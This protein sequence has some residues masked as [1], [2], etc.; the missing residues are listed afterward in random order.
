MQM[1]HQA[2]ACAVK[3]AAS[4]VCA[5]AH[6]VAV[7]DG[8]AIGVRAWQVGLN[9]AHGV[10]RIGICGRE[11]AGTPVRLQPEAESSLIIGQRA[12]CAQY[13]MLCITGPQ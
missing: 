8:V 12:L 5:V 13:S 6:H 10:Q 9:Q 11:T 7:A 1:P 4:E 3:G 2:E